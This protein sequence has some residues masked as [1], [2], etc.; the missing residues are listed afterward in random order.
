MA[1]IMAVTIIGSTMR[2]RSS[3][4]EGCEGLTYQLRGG[5]ATTMYPEWRKERQQQVELSLPA[6]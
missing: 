4:G 3:H 6:L 5:R 2:I 1:I